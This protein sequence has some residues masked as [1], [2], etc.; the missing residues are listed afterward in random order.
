MILYRVVVLVRYILN[1]RTNGLNII[2]LYMDFEIPFEDRK[3]WHNMENPD[4]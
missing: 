4:N 1:G 3:L 2:G